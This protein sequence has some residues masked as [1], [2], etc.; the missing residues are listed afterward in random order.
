MC[1]YFNPIAAK[2]T[3][4]KDNAG[5][6]HITIRPSIPLVENALIAPVPINKQEE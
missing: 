3:S 6:S 2:S 1:F 4:G 5:K